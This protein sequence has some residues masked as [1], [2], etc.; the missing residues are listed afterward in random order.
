LGEAARIVAFSEQAG[1]S[2]LDD[3]TTATIE[4]H[5]GPL[6]FLGTSMVIPDIA[7]TAVW[8]TGG[9]A[10]NDND[11]ERLLTQ[12]IGS[13]QWVEQE[14]ETLDTVQ[15]E[16]EEFA[17]NVRTGDSPE[18]DGAVGLEATVILEGI[19]ESSQRGTVVDLDEIRARE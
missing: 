19:V 3:T 17:R 8:G 9:A 4:F 18:T 16:L 5:E 13:K 7:R 6:A 2:E 10:C 15:D 12:E 1:V 11:G 14:V